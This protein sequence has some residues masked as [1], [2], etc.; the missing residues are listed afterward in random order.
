[1]RGNSV[2]L[3]LLVASSA[4]ATLSNAS[5]VDAS[6][7]PATVSQRYEAKEHYRFNLGGPSGE[8]TDWERQDLASFD[9]LATK[10]QIDKTYGKPTDKW[11]SLARINLFGAGSEKDRR[12]LSLMLQAD[13][14]SNRIQPAI[15]R[16]KD[17]PQETFD[18]QFEVGKPIDVTI[19]PG[20]VGKLM[21]SLGGKTYEVPCDFEV[22]ALSVLG[23]GVD[24]KFE[25]F[26]LL[27]RA[28]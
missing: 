3:A 27:R 12:I 15:Y 26:N 10:V 1:M 19:L 25:P 4:L 2:V 16:S 6:S 18:V 17:Q 28:P 7:A 8:Y 5:A 22:K 9:G 20:T 23:S 24:V 13:R 21:F 14:K 11:A